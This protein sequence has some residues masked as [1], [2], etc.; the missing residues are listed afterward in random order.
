MVGKTKWHETFESFVSKPS[1]E[2]HVIGWV[3]KFF[4]LQNYVPTEI[5]KEFFEPVVSYAFQLLKTQEKWFVDFFVSQAEVRE[6]LDLDELKD[7][8]MKYI[9]KDKSN[10]LDNYQKFKQIT[11]MSG[12]I[13]FK[14]KEKSN[15]QN[16]ILIYMKRKYE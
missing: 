1:T 16:L 7:Q 14:K 15:L 4:I 5:Q 13:Y 9:V 2:T 10:F 6:K 8:L 12:I 3:F 11:C